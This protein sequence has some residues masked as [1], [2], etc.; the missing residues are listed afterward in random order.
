MI[1]ICKKNA[2]DAGVK[3]V[4]FIQGN[5]SQIPF[6]ENNFNFIVCVLAFKNFKNP[7][8]VLE[9]MYRVLRP[10]STALIMDLDGKASL[11]DTKKVAGLLG[12]TAVLLFNPVSIAVL[13]PFW[14]LIGK[15]LQTNVTS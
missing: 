10:G 6:P 12:L 13:L 11:Q 2:A 14:W 1:E 5:A 3:N 8:K 7:T 4:T 15:G 9:E